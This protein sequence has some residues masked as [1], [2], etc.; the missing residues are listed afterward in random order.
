[1]EEQTNV[2]GDYDGKYTICSDEYEDEGTNVHS[3]FTRHM[4]AAAATLNKTTPSAVEY[5]ATKMS[6]ASPSE[7]TKLESK[8]G[9]SS[10]AQ[11]S[12]DSGV[13]GYWIAA[14]SLIDVNRDDS[15]LSA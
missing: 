11:T 1:M 12:E 14:F 9:G 5:R 2:G 7:P 4:T 13:M 6:L 3:G 15:V 8:C 10:L